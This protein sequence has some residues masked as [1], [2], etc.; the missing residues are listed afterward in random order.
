MITCYEWK[1]WKGHHTV[2]LPFSSRDRIIC[3]V[4]E[5]GHPSL[6]FSPELTS[7]FPC[8]NL[9]NFSKIVM[10][11]NGWGSQN[12]HPHCHVHLGL[13]LPFLPLT[14]YSFLPPP[15]PPS[16]LP[17][18]FLSYIC[19]QFCL[20]LCLQLEESILVSWQ[21][22][23]SVETSPSFAL[24]V[25]MDP[26]NSSYFALE[27]QFWSGRAICRDIWVVC[28]RLLL[29]FDHKSSMLTFPS[30]RLFLRLPQYFLLMFVSI[31]W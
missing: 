16:S 5:G 28:I 25:Q 11:L 9:P 27:I 22:N 13:Q 24:T 20:M 18:P 23:W 6:L 10:F 12:V 19:L 17:H 14:P 30:W 15:P 7:G 2:K 21:E 26:P 29:P 1:F 31:P 4:T 8:L 3:E